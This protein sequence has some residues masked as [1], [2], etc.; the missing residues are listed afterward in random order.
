VFCFE[1]CP[2]VG[3]NDRVNEAFGITVELEITSQVADFI[4]QILL[5]LACGGSSIVKTL[6]QT[7]F[8]MRWMVRVEVDVSASAGGFS[9]DFGDPFLMTRTSRTAIALS[10]SISMVNWMD[11]LKLLRWLRKSCTHDGPRS[12]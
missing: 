8:H 5:F 7:P 10:D 6:D 3:I 2:D 4:S 12:G 11:G 9:V 1:D